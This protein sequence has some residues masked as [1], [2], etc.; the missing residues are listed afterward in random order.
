MLRKLGIEPGEGR[1]FAWG[2]AALFLLGWADV[3]VKNVSEAFF[4]KR[5]GVE[6]LPYA[7]LV[8]ATLLVVTTWAFGNFAVRRDR[9]R[10]LPQTFFGLALLLGLLVL[11]VGASLPFFGPVVR[12][13]A[14]LAGLGMLAHQLRERFVASRALT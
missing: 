9:L 2:A 3:S 5:V 6:L 13:L 11:A 4:I 8:S 7:F 1:V 10:L 12:V 14:A